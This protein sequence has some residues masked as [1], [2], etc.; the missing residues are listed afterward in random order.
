MIFGERVKQARDIFGLTQEELA[1]KVGVQQSTIARIENDTLSPSLDLLEA[2]SRQTGF[3]PSFFEQEPV[4][5]FSLGTLAFRK[6]KLLSAQEESKAYQYAKIMYEHTRTMFSQLK[7]SPPRLPETEGEEP[8]V[9]ARI[10][11]T[12]LGL[13]PDTPI[14]NLMKVVEG[15]GLL[16]FLLPLI[17]SKIDAFSTWAQLD[18]QR[19]FI[20][21]SLG[22]PTDRLRF[23]ISHE[24]GHLVMHRTLKGTLTNLEQA[25]DQF[26]AEF[27]M[28]E[29]AMKR[30]LIPPI[31]LTRVAKLKP[32]WGV[33]MQALIKRARTL[34]I[35]S[36]RQYRY[37]CQQISAHGWKKQEPS[38]L[39]L[40]P[41]KPQSIRKMAEMLHKDIQSYADTM[42][43][44]LG[45]AMEL[46]V[47]S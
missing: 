26:A 36:E 14:R 34:G 18:Y 28:P 29:S 15:N 32:K 43:L 13:S 22:K 33:S 31:T 40:T 4:D 21:V 44:R 24:L 3:L 19:P 27:L 16:I 45:T 9:A 6:H 5:N 37:L 17:L 46:F 38:N 8:Q 10:A 12:S 11:R 2:I 20:A 35:L 1:T 41:E 30:E 39:D 23:S 25:A 47:F 7:V 42:H